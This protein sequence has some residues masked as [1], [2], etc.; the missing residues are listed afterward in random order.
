MKKPVFILLVILSWT[1]F[2]ISAV[3]YFKRIIPIKWYTPV[4]LYLLS[5]T[6][7]I[8]FRFFALDYKSRRKN[9]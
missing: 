5:A 6:W 1:G 9:Y 4:Y 3:L 7:A 2:L 8:I